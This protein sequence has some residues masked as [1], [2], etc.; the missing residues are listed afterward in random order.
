VLRFLLSLAAAYGHKMYRTLPPFHAKDCDEKKEPTQK[1][2]PGPQSSQYKNT[3]GSEGTLLRKYVR[4]RELRVQIAD[5]KAEIDRLIAV[6]EDMAPRAEL[7]AARKDLKSSRELCEQQRAD[8]A[9][10]K[11]NIDQVREDLL[12]EKQ[13]NHTLKAQIAEMAPKPELFK[14]RSEAK[15][16]GDR[17]EKLQSDYDATSTELV[18]VKESYKVTA[19][20]L[21]ESR[22]L[23]K[24]ADAA[25]KSALY[26]L[27]ALKKEKERLQAAVADLHEQL[28]GKVIRQRPSIKTLDTKS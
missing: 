13:E 11:H 19:A 4:G 10:L 20:D 24:E 22:R 6:I 23:H 16:L 12:A 2:H 21:D 26:E 8:L 7:T 9:S 15:Q 14:A 25:H 3:A 27:E 5:S 17:V 18:S 1:K 28:V